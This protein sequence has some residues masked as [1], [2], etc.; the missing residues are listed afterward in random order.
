MRLETLIFLRDTFWGRPAQDVRHSGGVLHVHTVW[1][2]LAS[3]SDE[4]V[5]ALD[6]IKKKLAQP[7]SNASPNAPQN[8]IESKPAIEAEVVASEANRGIGA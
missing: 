7:V 6:A 8:Q 3:L 2:P 5:A 4:E 1:R